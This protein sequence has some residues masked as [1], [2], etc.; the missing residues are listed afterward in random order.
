MLSI[1]HE[2][3]KSLDEGYGN[4]RVFLDISKASDKVWHKGLFHKLEEN[5]MSGKL[6]NIVKDFLYQRKQRVVLNGQHSSWAAIEAGVPQGSI[7]GALLFLIYINDLFDDLASM[8]NYLQMIH[9]Y[10]LW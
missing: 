3:Y 5:G 10:F 9:H 8:Q 1:T 4:R 2:I 7:L 6:L